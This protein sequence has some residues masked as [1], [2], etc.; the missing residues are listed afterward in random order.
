MKKTN[1]E[2]FMINV[3]LLIVL[4]VA[5]VLNQSCS[6][7]T[8]FLVSSEVPAAEGDV[9]ISKSKFNNFE[10]KINILHLAEPERLKP[11]KAAYVVWIE[12]ENNLTKNLGQ[13]ESSS[14]FLSKKLK[15]S[16]KTVSPFNPVKVYITAEDRPNIQ[17]PQGIVVLTTDNF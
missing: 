2:Q 5:S 6:R 13:I 1:K 14:G 3:L 10:I 17:Y 9:K 15:I 7:K 12:T 4:V 8:N 11:P 16:F